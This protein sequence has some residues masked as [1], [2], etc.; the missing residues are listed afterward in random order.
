MRGDNDGARRSMQNYL[1]QYPKGAF[2]SNA[3]YYLGSIAFSQ[4]N[5]DE[6]ETFF[7]S[8]IKSGD[9][10]FME[11]AVARKSE[12]QYNR[13]DY[14]AALETF[15]RLHKI[16]ENPDNKEAASLGVMRCALQIGDEKEALSA[17]NDLLKNQK[18]SP[19]IA[20]E[21]RYVRAKAYMDSKNEEKALADLKILAEDTRT[22]HGAEARYLLAQLY[23]DSH[24]DKKAEK[25]LEDFAKNGTPHQYWLARGF[26]LWAD[27]YIRQGDDVQAR[28]YLN[29]LKNNYQG[30][31]DIA[32]MIE[33]RLAKINQKGG[34]DEN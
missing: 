18:V 12:I 10:K 17:A 1:Q 15:R 19:E 22:V 26:I 7:D 3:N 20:A 4:K 5:Y 9:M 24:E 27:I 11:E 14:A 21:A 32:A 33:D 31:D 28:V 25:V 34:S 8:V 6:A 29:S 30:D 16:A 23:Y 13:N 2:S